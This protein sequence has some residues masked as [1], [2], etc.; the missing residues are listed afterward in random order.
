MPFA[1]SADAV[2]A[3]SGTVLV[4][5]RTSAAVLML[6]RRS[7]LRFMGGY[8]VFPGGAVDTLDTLHAGP[9]ASAV[10]TAAVAACRELEEE[11]GLRLEP[12][13]LVHWAHWITPSAAQRRFDT[14]FFVALAPEHQLAHLASDESDDLRWLD[15]AT[16]ADV[17]HDFPV[18]PP[19]LFELRAVAQLL[20]GF[21][22][23]AAAVDRARSRSFRSVLPKLVDGTAVMPWDP[24]YESLRGAGIEWDAAARAERSGWPSRVPAVVAPRD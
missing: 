13:A 15:A 21:G 16:A 22:S 9:G 18:T 3:P 4:L 5:D 19:T 12:T 17:V 23:A 10:R 2:A 14:H 11:A 24:D 20:A 1:D 6:R 8:W 7:S